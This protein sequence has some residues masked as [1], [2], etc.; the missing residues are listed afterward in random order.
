MRK[1]FIFIICA[2]IYGSLFPFT[3]VSGDGVWERWNI[4]YNSFSPFTSLGDILGNIVLFIPFGFF[5][6]KSLRISGAGRKIYFRILIYGF[7]LALIIQLIQVYIPSRSPAIADVYWNMAGIILG[8]GFARFLKEYFPKFSL[9]DAAGIPVI[10]SFIWLLSLFFPFVPTIDFQEIKNGLKPL[11]LDPSF[12][13]N[14]FLIGLTGWLLFAHFTR[15]I[16]QRNS[17]HRFRLPIFAL[18]SLPM[19]LLI[20]GNNIDLSDAM[21]VF[22]AMI[23]WPMVARSRLNREKFFAI[24]MMITIF[25]NGVWSPHFIWHN[26]NFSWV[27][28]SGFLEGSIFLNAK[29]LFL[30][31]FLYG[32]L[33]YLL[34]SGW[35]HIRLRVFMAFSFILMIEILQIFMAARTAEITDPLIILFISYIITRKKTAPTTPKQDVPKKPVQRKE[36]SYILLKR[37]LGLLLGSIALITIAL[38]I[39]IKLPGV[40]Y[41]VSELFRLDGMFIAILPFAVFIIWFGMSIP[42]ISKRMLTIPDYHFIR[43]PIWVMGSGLVSYLLLKISVTSETLADVTGS[44]NI[45]WFVKNHEIW[46]KPGLFLTGIIP[47]PEVWNSLENLVRF[48]A[49]FSPVTFTLCLFYFIGDLVKKYEIT[50]IWSQLRLYAISLP[51]YFLYILPWLFLCKIIAFDYSSTDN[52]NELIARDSFYGL[53]GGMYLYLLVILLSL[54]SVW[55]SQSKRH[56]IFKITGTFISGIITWYLLNLGLEANVEKYG[57]T[58]SGV[59]FLLGPDRKI[60]LDETILFMRWFILYTS[61]IAILAWGMKFNILS[62]LPTRETVTAQAENG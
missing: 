45:L 61:A 20:L 38:S 26:L 43:F 11:I 62:L 6:V 59:D 1:L 58:F 19:R 46:G 24:L 2:I 17:L 22:G 4:L 36:P 27:P 9:T 30:K 35:P 52:L 50:G 13:G 53:G 25:L 49:L 5:G 16:F 34:K 37:K 55:V 40:P 48:L 15:D 32:S 10:L 41:N 29:A 44:N 18:L 51:I 47:D 54:N 56:G 31:A 14:I 8:L 21:A 60:K 23:I 12:Q 7:F 39:L 57:L 33:V 3:F 28:F 42:L